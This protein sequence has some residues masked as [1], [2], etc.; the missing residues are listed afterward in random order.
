MSTASLVYDASINGLSV[1]DVSVVQVGDRLVVMPVPR[2][3]ATTS[4]FTPIDVPNDALLQIGLSPSSASRGQQVP[5]E[6]ASAGQT[7]HDYAAGAQQSPSPV[8]AGGG[9]I[10]VFAP[11]QFGVPQPP[12]GGQPLGYASSHAVPALPTAAP[13]NLGPTNLAPTNLAPNAAGPL[14]SSPA[15]PHLSAPQ[16]PPAFAR[17]PAQS[18]VIAASAQPPSSS[19]SSNIPVEGAV[20]GWRSYSET[21]EAARPL[22]VAP[23]TR[24]DD[25][26]EDQKRSWPYVDRRV[27]DSAGKPPTIEGR[28][29]AVDTSP[30]GLLLRGMSVQSPDY[31]VILDGIVLRYPD[32]PSAAING[33]QL[34]IH[35]GDF[36][37]LTGP[38]NSGKSS[39]LSII[40]GHRAANAGR[41]IIGGKDFAKLSQEDRLT[42]EALSV[43]M[44]GACPNFAPDLTVLENVEIPLLWAGASAQ[45]ARRAAHE[46]LERLGVGGI[47]LRDSATLS[48]SELRLAGLARTMLGGGDVIV[49]DDPTAGLDDD[50]ALLVLGQLMEAQTRHVAV[51]MA[52]TDARIRLAG[53]R[54][55]T[56]AEGRIVADGRRLG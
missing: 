47:G 44:I 2:S 46:A 17:Q 26:P 41:V 8:P 56:M 15:V 23:T 16:I 48:T 43:Q 22:D 24:L 34:A 49:A 33:I 32:S 10:Q 39:L 20:P 4:G 29:P 31:A 18:D 54:H 14:P 55:L 28:L 36:V 21:V 11:A 3:V 37:I 25:V 45:L 53:P 35:A 50:T 5:F 19:N 30:T 13:T 6:A 1:D 40:A 27:A 12:N 52:T 9:E 38:R 7:R 51:V 42:R